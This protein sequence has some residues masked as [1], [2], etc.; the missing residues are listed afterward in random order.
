MTQRV[1]RKEWSTLEVKE[2]MYKEWTNPQENG[3][4]RK[5]AGNHG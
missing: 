5:Y 2:A 1:P 3:P 4:T